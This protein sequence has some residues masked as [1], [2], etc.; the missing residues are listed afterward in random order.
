MTTLTAKQTELLINELTKKIASARA[1]LD[2]ALAAI[3]SSDPLLGFRNRGEVAMTEAARISVYSY[4]LQAV[5]EMVDFD[6][7]KE[8]K[9]LTASLLSE[10]KNMQAYSGLIYQPMVM[11]ERKAKA[12]MIE[13]LTEIV[14]ITD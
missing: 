13:L 11:V 6:P 3:S 10:A 7:T 5:K 8:C 9:R 1:E 14:D 4:Y 12:E 2:W